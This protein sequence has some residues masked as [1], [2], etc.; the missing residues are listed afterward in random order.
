MNRKLAL[1]VAIAVSLVS[2]VVIG[3]GLRSSWHG[4]E[5]GLNLLVYAIAAA[6]AGGLQTVNESRRDKPKF[7]NIGIAALLSFIGL[8]MAAYEWLTKDARSKAG[9][10]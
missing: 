10:Q 4:S 6:L 7:E 1:V 5:D 8:G 9:D 2:M 3:E